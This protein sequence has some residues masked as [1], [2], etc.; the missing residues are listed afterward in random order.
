MSCFFHCL[1][2]DEDYVAGYLPDDGLFYLW[3]P[4]PESQSRVDP[5]YPYML[6]GYT[7]DGSVNILKFIEDC[8]T[9]KM[10]DE[11]Q[12]QYDDKLLNMTVYSYYTFLS[13]LEHI[14]DTDYIP[15]LELDW[16]LLR[17]AC[18]K[19]RE[20]TK[21]NFDKYTYIQKV[22]QLFTVKNFSDVHFPQSGVE[23]EFDDYINNKMRAFDWD[24]E[25][26]LLTKKGD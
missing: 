18:N 23:V 3:Y 9:I 24:L 11:L 26:L 1:H 20:M 7:M 17:D 10:T 22:E 25:T 14:R 19:L 21:E 5:H 13:F 2:N 4:N 6:S 12:K 8:K 15:K 16:T